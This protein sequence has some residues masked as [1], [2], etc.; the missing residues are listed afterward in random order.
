LVRNFEEFQNIDDLFNYYGFRLA[1]LING[2]AVFRFI[3]L[4]L[5]N[6]FNLSDLAT[7]TIIAFVIS[8]IFFF[9]YSVNIKSSKNIYWLLLLFL[10]VFL[11]PRI[12]NL[13]ASGLRSGIAFTILIIAIMYLK[14]SK[15]YI[16]FGLSI[17]IHLSMAPMIFFYFLF[18]WLKNRKNELSFIAGLFVLLICSF[19]FATLAPQL[20]FNKYSSG[21]TSINQSIYYMSL[22][23]FVGLA[24]IFTNKKA[25]RNVYGFMSIGLILIVLI[26]FIIDFSYVRYIGN[27]IILYLFFLIQEGK[28][29][30]FQTFTLGYAPFFALTLFYSIANYW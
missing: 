24:I 6:F 25:I 11:T 16:L 15:K 19:F 27:A 1:V 18:Y 22:V 10:M 12:I 2:D 26:G 5:R 13:F 17:L 8:S 20:I 30:T 14:G 9:I 21:N 7:L 3:V 4:A 23:I 28:L 29:K